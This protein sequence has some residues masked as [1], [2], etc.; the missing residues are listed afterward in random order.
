MIIFKDV[1]RTLYLYKIGESFL[2]VSEPL[3]DVKVFDYCYRLDNCIIKVSDAGID[4]ID[5]TYK[6]VTET[7]L[8]Y[9]NREKSNL[10]CDGC[11]TGCLNTIRFG[12]NKDYC[13][14]C[15]TSDM[16]LEGLEEVKKTKNTIIEYEDSPKTEIEII[17]DLRCDYDW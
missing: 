11:R 8:K 15:L 7:L 17:R 10:K 3:F 4:I 1:S 5:G 12:Y 13:L 14:S 2:L 16:K 9:L 6:D